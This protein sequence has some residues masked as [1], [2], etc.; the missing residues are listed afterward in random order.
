MWICVASGGLLTSMMLSTG[1]ILSVSSFR[2]DTAVICFIW[3][4][5]DTLSTLTMM[6]VAFGLVYLMIFSVVYNLAL[7]KEHI[8]RLN[9]I[10]QSDSYP[11]PLI[12]DLFSGR[13]QRGRLPPGECLIMDH[14]RLFDR[15]R[16]YS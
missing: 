4:A 2:W 5:I 3:C 12:S 11:I 14:W 13:Q 7:I 16:S 15:I 1:H 6:N 10:R 8:R 9:L